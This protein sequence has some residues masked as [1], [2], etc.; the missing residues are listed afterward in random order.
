MS[1][2]GMAAG[3]P[4]VFGRT[5]RRHPLAVVGRLVLVALTVLAVGCGG[6]ATPRAPD[7]SPVGSAPMTF[8]GPTGRRALTDWSLAGRR[9]RAPFAVGAR[10]LDMPAFEGSVARFS[11]AFYLPAA[12][13]YAIRFESVN[14]KAVVWLDGR[15][16]A[17]HTGTYL[18]FEVRAHLGGG[19][20]RLVVRDDWRDPVRMRAAGWHR[21]WFNYGGLARE[22]TIRPLGASELDSPGLVARVTAGGA[23]VTVTVRVRNRR[24]DRLV[25][26]RG[27]VAGAPLAFPA[28]RLAAGRAAWVS[29]RVRLPHVRLWEPGRPALYPLEL[30]V[31]G[32]SGYRARVGLR[33]LRWRGGRLRLNGRTLR[34][35]GVS[36]QED[37][38]GRGDA[39]R[40]ADMDRIVARLRALHANATRAQH[41][42]SPALL[43]RLDAAGILVWQGIGPVDHPGEW[44]GTAA[45]GVRRARLSLLDLRAHPSVLTWSLANE[46]KANGVSAGQRAY[47]D[48][49]AR[50]AHRLDPGRPVAADVWGKYLP[51]RAGRMYRAVDVI[52]GTNYEG[53]YAHLHS[54]PATVGAAISDWLARFERA[55]GR[56]V[57]VVSEFGAEGDRRN[58]AGAPGGLAFQARLVARHI[59]AYR[60]DPRLS[61]MI[62][63][64]LRD[65]AMKP[66][67]LG[68]S[69]RRYAPQIVLRRGLNQKGLF[70]YD[71]RA[72]PAARVVGALFAAAAA[73][74][75]ASRGRQG[76]SASSPSP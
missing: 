29:A 41:P 62:V 49:A 1:L 8:G 20:H 64:A 72:K 57:L 38:R 18:P 7:P 55:F 71:D 40:P 69:V 24:A 47:V 75:G 53:W 70:T 52:G 73:R 36:L 51:A 2:V 15:L 28:V 35:R 42:L 58:P 30:A 14:H 61:G 66:N 25:R 9:V 67:F 13:D 32:E 48:R 63:W 10:R 74:A 11:T 6:H 26:V 12:G 54:A 44:A 3:Y 5:R 39:L 17:R 27:S 21:T 50:L 31:S 23:D 19:R 33:E 59:R 65:F 22:V 56:R 34:L 4:G 16:V 60:D 43:E 37:A 76:R 46:V 45:L 68:G